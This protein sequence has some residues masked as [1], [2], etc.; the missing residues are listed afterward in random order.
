ML[1]E[2]PLMALTSVGHFEVAARRA[3]RRG[4]HAGFRYVTTLR[5][6]SSAFSVTRT[7]SFVLPVWITRLPSRVTIMFR[8]RPP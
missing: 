2:R 1:L 4:R 8:R 5:R 3:N 7:I 6:Q